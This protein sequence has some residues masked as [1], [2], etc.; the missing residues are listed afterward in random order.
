MSEKAG[1]IERVLGLYTKLMSGGI[2]YKAEEA[3]N[4]D[5]DERSIARD[6]SDIREYLDLHGPEEGAI[7][8]IVF[9][10]VAGGYRLEEVFR[11]KFTNAEVLAICKILLESRA[12]TKGE[13]DEMLKKLIESSVP[14]ENQKLI[15]DLIRNE[16]F[17]Y[18]EP[19]HKSVFIDKMWQIGLAIHEHNYIEIKYQGIQGHTP[20]K[21][22]LKPLAIMFSDFYFYLAAFIEDDAVRENFNIINDANPTI[23][24]IDRIQEFKV[25][26]EKYSTLYAN[27]FEEGEF[28]KRI[29]FMSPGKLRRVLFEYRGYS[30]EAVLD[31]LPTAEIIEEHFDYD[32]GRDVYKIR[33]E[34]Y[35]DGIDM[36]LRSQGD[37]IKV[38]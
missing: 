20:K 9:D 35:G 10:R 1:K 18:I 34:V 22:K 24:R 28:R 3:N 36:W 38:L 25:L 29:Q 16:E 26:D 19:H 2:V 14:I 27:R 13:I 4:Y 12:F 33:A 15:Q 7:N 17:H 37:N 8:T 6:I 31:R 32:L 23:Y 11:Q 30:V 5:V 21:R